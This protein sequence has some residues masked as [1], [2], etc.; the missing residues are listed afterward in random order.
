MTFDDVLDMLDAVNA[1][2]GAA[3]VSREDGVRHSFPIFSIVMKIEDASFMDYLA[4]VD[5]H[6]ISEV[7]DADGNELHENGRQDGDI[8]VWC[9][10][11]GLPDP[12]AVVDPTEP[13]KEYQYRD[14]LLAQ[15]HLSESQLTEYDEFY[16]HKD[17]N[18]ETDWA[19]V[20][21]ATQQ[22]TSS[23]WTTPCYY[24]F[25]NRVME[26]EYCGEPFSF[27]VGVFSVSD[28]RF[29]DF[30]APELCE[31]D[32]LEKVWTEIGIGRLIGDT[33]GNNCLE[34]IDATMIQQCQAN[35]RDYPDDDKNIP[36][37]MVLYPL[38]YFSDFD[39]DG[40]RNI[41]DA[42]AIQRYLGGLQYRSAD[43]A[44]YPHKPK[45]EPTEPEPA[46][47][48]PTPTEQQPTE[49]DIDPSIP[50]IT[51]FKST[52]FGVEISLSTVPGAEKYRVYYWS[53]ASND[54]KSMGETT[55]STFIDND[56]KAGT[57]YRYTVRCIK[58]DLSA[59]TSDFY[60]PGWS[61]TYDPHL[62]AP[63][64]TKLEAVSN[65]I[66]I[67]W[68]AVDGADLY[69]V[70][71]QTEDGWMKL[72]DVRGTEYVDTTARTGHTYTYSVRCLSQGGKGYA[73]GYSESRTMQ[74]LYEPEILGLKTT[75][76]GIQ[77][78]VH[79]WRCP[80][81]RVYRKSDG[82]G[83][84]RIAEIEPQTYYI[85]EDVE[86]GKTY[87]YTARCLNE[88]GEF[89]SYYNT[90]GFTH[91]Y[92]LESYRPE[93]E[94]SV[95]VRDNKL[96][97]KMEENKFNLTDY[98]ILLK[99]F[100]DYVGGWRF[101]DSIAY[102]TDPALEENR[103]VHFSIVGI[104]EDENFITDY[105]DVTVRTLKGPEDLKVRRIIGENGDRFYGAEWYDPFSLHYE[106]VLIGTNPDDEED[107]IIIE[108]PNIG[109]TAWYKFDLSEY[110]EGY[111]W[112]F[113]IC[114]YT[115]NCW[116]DI[117]SVTFKESDYH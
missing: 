65:G 22:Q 90:K 40:E 116:S 84:Q 105:S 110:P 28:D 92:T 35:L 104:D 60:H 50:R 73:S 42:T 18:G 30:S 34:I 12:Y 21:A 66:K 103:Q 80:R 86:P 33:D 44:P 55:G 32:G 61:Y 27:N 15:Y 87:T 58:A 56:V 75:S 106:A 117:Y 36:I 46:P 100:G 78:Y 37:D 76:T 39:Q 31:L 111:E 63:T 109:K 26:I 98:V 62:D 95:Y 6:K 79:E 72:A 41:T 11:R 74:F 64:I 25:G 43:W 53:K 70:C 85:D 77:L 83:C 4:K 48:E 81:V 102:I 71:Y 23:L 112:E 59:F 94:Y 52:G 93:M 107:Q 97:V 7:I 99:Q 82:G 38:R 13:V 89:C 114:G 88:A 2:S 19:L 96:I 54:W 5:D 101:S 1:K 47:T 91:S 57:T 115:E 14:K 45:I 51:G 108:I 69:R 20:R 16:E 24:E 113:S 68:N 8:V 49:P 9:T 10:Q 67:V 17:A 3:P 29:F